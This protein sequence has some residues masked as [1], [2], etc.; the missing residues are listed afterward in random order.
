MLTGLRARF[1]ENYAHY[2]CVGC[3]ALILAHSNIM[4][5]VHIS[6]RHLK[7]SFPKRDMVVVTD[8]VRRWSLVVTAHYCWLLL[9]IAGSYW[10]LWVTTGYCLFLR[11]S[12]CFLLLVTAG[13]Y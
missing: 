13:Y 8:G 7:S 11:V 9:I 3:L 12:D 1:T 5:H 4:P 10:L 6:N 2:R